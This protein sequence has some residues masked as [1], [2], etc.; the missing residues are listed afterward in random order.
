MELHAVGMLCALGAAGFAALR[1]ADRA[2]M[3]AVMAGFGAALGAVT[4]GRFPE[5]SSIG[6]AAVVLAAVALFRPSLWLAAALA[7][8]AF[9]GLWVSVLRAQGLPLAPALVLAAA[10]PAAAMALTTRRPRFAPSVLR[11]EA[12]LLVGGLGLVV[13][14]GP[15][16]VAGFES[17]DAFA[18]QPLSGGPEASV[19]WLSAFVA[20]CVVLGG[21]YSLWKRR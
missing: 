14:L 13:A 20:G 2:G 16:L 15:P 8:G 6:A 11:E 3:A 18:S 1:A 21:L 17:A 19:G 7:A 12:L 4:A 10:V 5:P 9:A